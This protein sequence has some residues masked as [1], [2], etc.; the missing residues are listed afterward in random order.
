MF[1]WP[2]TTLKKKKTKKTKT[3]PRNLAIDNS[4][5]QWFLKI[6]WAGWFGW[7]G[8]HMLLFGVTLG[9]LSEEL[10]SGW[11]TQMTSVICWLSWVVGWFGPNQ[12]SLSLHGVSSHS[13]AWSEFLYVVMGF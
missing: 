11:T 8:S 1:Q 6:V 13:V 4:N 7:G 5:K 2:T 3:L 10:H 9:V 12:A